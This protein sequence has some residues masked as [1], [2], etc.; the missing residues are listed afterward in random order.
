MEAKVNVELDRLVEYMN[1]R[2]DPA[3]PLTVCIGSIIAS[4]AISE[5]Y[6]FEND[7]T[8]E[9]LLAANTEMF[10]A[11]QT[12][13]ILLLNNMAWLSHVPL[14]GHFGLDRVQ[15]AE[16]EV[17]AHIP[18][19]R[20]ATQFRNYFMPMIEACDRRVRSE[21]AD[22]E[23]D[24][25]MHAFMLE[26]NRRRLAG[27]PADGFECVHSFPDRSIGTV[28]TVH[29]N[30]TW[31]CRICGARVWRRQRQHSNGPYFTWPLYRMCRTR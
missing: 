24:S 17:R 30:C 14:F 11:I 19:T 13:P 26:C 5:R 3:A 16:L 12:L 22:V 9:R 6:A 31:P 7:A 29:S 8:F 20:H 23:P 1:G 27:E 21:E 18:R 10:E 15:R 28:L 4:V 2:L 25:Y